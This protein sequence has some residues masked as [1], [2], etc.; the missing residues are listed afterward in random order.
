[1]ASIARD[2]EPPTKLKGPTFNSSFGLKGYNY[3]AGK[4]PR[5]PFYRVSL[6]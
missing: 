5:K 3:S 1:M 4:P 2:C 6:R